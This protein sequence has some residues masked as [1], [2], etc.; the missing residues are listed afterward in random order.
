MFS[1][2]LMPASNET[3]ISI[4]QSIKFSISTKFVSHDYPR[5]QLFNEHVSGKTRLLELSV[6][7]NCN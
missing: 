7:G 2:H 6:T 1:H 4:K 5:V 3:Y